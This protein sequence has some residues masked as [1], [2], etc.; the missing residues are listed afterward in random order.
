MTN[1][2]DQPTILVAAYQPDHTPLLACRRQVAAWSAQR[3]F[4][5]SA[6]NGLVRKSQVETGRAA[7]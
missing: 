1:R 4:S 6:A 2:K 7:S 3:S 5:L